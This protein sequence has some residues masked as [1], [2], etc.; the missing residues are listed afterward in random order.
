MG[1]N[2]KNK[3]VEIMAFVLSLLMSIA[4]ILVVVFKDNLSIYLQI[5]SV[6]LLLIST[7][8]IVYYGRLKNYKIPYGFSLVITIVSLKFFFYEDNLFNNIVFS[9]ISLLFVV[10]YS[11]V[12]FV[13]NGKLKAII[14]HSLIIPMQLGIMFLEIIPLIDK[15]S[16]VGSNLSVFWGL[17]ISCVAVFL[18]DLLSDFN[19][20]FSLGYIIMIYVTDSI[21]LYYF[22]SFYLVI[23][24][25]LSYLITMVLWNFAR[26]KVL[27][28]K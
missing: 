16:F 19:I 21:L 15:N 26:R 4:I 3:K 14:S 8:I 10:F 9:V 24:I 7:A 22:H 17:I 28:Q 12:V 1:H 25:I 23:P 18:S 5:V 13:N 20:L 2:F 11:L 27:M 6:L